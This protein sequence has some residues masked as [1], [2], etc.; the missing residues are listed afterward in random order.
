MNQRFILI[1]L[2]LGLSALYPLTAPA[3]SLPPE[4]NIQ[5]ADIIKDSWQLLVIGGGLEM[6][7]SMQT[8]Y[9]SEVQFSDSAKTERNFLLSAETLQP[10][11]QLS[12]FK[13]LPDQTQSQLNTL[14]K[15]FYANPAKATNTPGVRDA[16]KKAAKDFDGGSFFTNLPNA[17]YYAIVDF[18]EQASERS[19]EVDFLNNKNAASSAIL[20]QFVQQANRKRKSD[21]PLRLVFSTASG[22]DPFSAV[23]FY[24]QTLEQAAQQALPDVTVQVQWLPVDE[25]V[26]D[27][28]AHQADCNDIEQLQSENELYNRNT[29][30]PKLAAQ[31][32]AM[33]NNPERLAELL[34]A[35][36]GLFING[37]DQMR[38]LRTFNRPFN[39]N[40]RLQDVI[41]QQ[42]MQNKLLLA[43]TSAG[44][45]VMAGNTLQNRP[46]P[47]ITGGQ[48][49][50]ALVR[51]AFAL[52]P[53]PFGCEKDNNCPNGLLEDDLTYK[54]AG[55]LGLFNA[56]IVDTHFSERD[57][58]GRLVMLAAFTKTR[59][60]FG[61]DENTALLV[62]QGAKSSL[63]MQVIGESGVFIADMQDAIFK[64]QSGKHQII[65]LSHYLNHGDELA[66]DTQNGQLLF[67]MAPG[68]KA[69]EQ[70]AMILNPKRGEFRRQVAINCGTQS[71]HRWSNNNIAWLVN[72]SEDTRFV[73]NTAF[74]NETCSYSNLL[75]GVE[76]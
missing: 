35:A 33:C 26:M 13:R 1:M 12:A 19:E 42:V 45:A 17:V 24:Q 66:L 2:A 54:P 39:G 37:G 10:V 9:C 40:I 8:D 16:F 18:T 76:N 64:S 74:G 30:Y 53:A 67:S 58:H 5:D 46:V 68:S 27:S 3:T 70:K 55:G 34:Q 15:Y 22:R 36:H 23:D 57:R 41:K 49:D 28:I 32:Q 56:G 14:F 20:T 50:V 51:G 7:S 29:V 48:S 25:S 31:Q 69:L 73:M 75:F 65:G 6:C 52:P 47:M 62:K 21:E 4:N 59:F 11:I 38:T 60:G 44:A 43:G 72:P 61:I 71:F 63:K